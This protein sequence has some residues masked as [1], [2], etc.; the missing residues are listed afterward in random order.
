[1]S[2]L[3]FP[4]A[5]AT[6]TAGNN[7]T[8]ATQL[9]RTANVTTPDITP[10][11]V[12]LTSTETPTVT[13]LFSVT[14]T[15]SEDVN[16]FDN[17]DITVANATVGNFVTLDAKTYS[18]DVTPA[19][20]G[21]VTVDVPAAIAT[22]TAG[23]NNTAATQ[24]VRTAN[25]TTPIVDV[26]P[27]T[28]NLSAISNITTAGGT[29]Q[30]LTVTFSDSSGVDVSSLDNSDVVV[31]WSG[32]AIPAT[33]ISATPTG[34]GTP[35]TATYSLTPPGGTWDSVDNGT[36]TV[37]LQASQVKDVVGNLSAASNLGTF[38][39]NVAAP[40]P[41]PAPAPTPPAVPTPVPSVTPTPAPTI[42]ETPA[43]TPC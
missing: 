37:N 22:D 42:A 30:T 16:G 38:S 1:M 21:N 41:A 24:L 10:P 9:V 2:P 27:P 7:N 32:G 43:Q 28:P 15:F 17:T 12:A 11:T 14:A 40:A 20:S 39:V 23:N 3:M 31:N 25:V 26:I 33:F 5:I 19:A 34:N 18:F 29:S 36:Y 6:D 4:A 35:R 13:G 8:A